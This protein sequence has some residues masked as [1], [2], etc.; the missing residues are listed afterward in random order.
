MY[1]W[2]ARQECGREEWRLTKTFDFSGLQDLEICFDLADRGILGDTDEGILIYVS[3]PSQPATQIFCLQGEPQYNQR[4][5]FYPYCAALPDWADDRG[6]VT[7]TLVGHAED[8]GE[9]LL[10][11]DVRVKGWVTSCPANATRI[12]RE[13]FSGCPNPITDGWNG[14]T[15]SGTPN[16]PGSW[17]CG[18]PSTSPSAQAIDETWTITRTVDTSAYDGNIELCF[19]IGDDNGGTSVTV[20]FDARQGAGWQTVWYQTGD[21][22]ADQTCRQICANLSDINRDAARNPALL[23]RFT[24]NAN[25]I[26]GDGWYDLDDIEV[27]GSTYCDAAGMVDLTAI[28]DSG[29]G[30]YG[31]STVDLTDGLM[32]PIVTCSWDS[33]PLPVSDFT[34]VDFIY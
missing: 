8:N 5:L 15:V 19:S 4:D 6:N 17:N 33:P 28:V 14:W 20:Q 13:T 21:L 18:S 22:G 10:M 7:I 27:Y 12:F 11:D 23:I 29:L 25:V 16:C 1:L 31:F 24:M 2:T 3:A 34:Y 30:H 26:P 9:Y 32:S